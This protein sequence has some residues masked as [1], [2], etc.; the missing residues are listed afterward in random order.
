[1][2]R[3]IAAI[4][5]TAI[6]LGATPSFADTSAAAALRTGDMKKL[7][8][9]TT[10]E[11]TSSVAFILPNG[12]G[13][14]TL[15]DYSGKYVLVN[16]WATWCAPCREEIPELNEFAHE[17]KTIQTIAIAIDDLESVNKFTNKIPIEYL[18][19]IAEN[20]GVQLSQS[21]GNER[22][23]LPFSV[24]ISPEKKIEK[25]FYGRLKLNQ[26]NQSLNSIIN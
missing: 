15:R 12:G 5:Y 7:V 14:K 24:I 2:K 25:V 20:E 23:I 6:A 21:L 19:L 13:E 3:Y 26:L 9:H 10:P 11:A 8:F 22:G 18:S 4:M 1:M 17:N 16:F